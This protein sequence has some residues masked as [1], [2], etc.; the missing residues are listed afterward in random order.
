MSD[1]AVDTSQQSGTLSD[2]DALAEYYRSQPGY[3]RI[4]KEYLLP[5]ESPA[6]AAAAVTAP[7]DASERDPATNYVTAPD[8]APAGSS[9]EKKRKR[10]QNKNRKFNNPGES[11]IKLCGNTA[12][13]KPCPFGASCKFTHSIPTYLA[14]KPP[15]ISPTCPV[16]AS[17][18]R[19]DAG[20][21]CR[22]LSGH[23]EK[24]VEDD[25]STWKLVVDEERART[26]EG[27][28]LN[29]VGR[30]AQKALRTHEMKLPKS[31]VYMAELEKEI[32]E[33]KRADAARAKINQTPENAKTTDA[34]PSS[35]ESGPGPTPDDL[36]DQRATYL[37]SRYRPQEKHRLHLSGAKI[38]APL[39]TVGNIPFRRICKSFGAD[40]TVSEMGL[41][42][43]LLQGHQPEWALP[44][45][46]I[47]ER[48]A[49]GRYGVQIAGGKIRNNVQAA[50]ALSTLCDDIDFIDLNSGCPID[51]VYHQGAGSALLDSPLKLLR[52]ARGM[53]QVSAQIPIT[54]KIRTG[55][56]DGHPTALNLIKRLREET[57]GGVQAVTL[58]GRSRQQRYTRSADWGYIQSCAEMV[59]S[60][61]AGEAA[62]DIRGV[63][64]EEGEFPPMAFVGNGDIYTFEDWHNALGTG[65]DAA[66]IARG[67]L[68]KPWIF[69]EIERGQHIDKTPTQRLDILRDFANHGLEYWGADAHGIAT[70]RRFLCESM[71]FMH[72]YIPVSVLEEG[73]KPS[74]RERAPRW[75]A[76]DGVEEMLG[77]GRCGDWVKLSEMFLG[78]VGEGWEFVPK[79]K[80]NSV[81]G[82]EA[83]G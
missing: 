69:E 51:L 77:S 35:A 33:A 6:A 13:N 52:M 39:T 29:V 14:S 42:A 65:V 44:R 70:T 20:W 27:D 81:E 54:V 10:G 34:Q 50:E 73:W 26:H 37:E 83:Q 36:A 43:P 12:L 31:E 74:M 24:V 2:P 55:T 19:C 5:R 25:M 30:D 53:S 9:R 15:D 46:H 4:K 68:I 66:M 17:T 60:A 18:G 23:V 16:F 61:R 48:S 8:P 56:R 78:P 62:S 79:H 11:G 28:Y 3:A 21:K 40:V 7:E 1:D 38:L 41:S 59:A 72:R 47:S 76:R 58:H 67:A 63:Q 45:A 71:S 75:R 80:S 82:E 22:F 57:L 49:G 64:A 32:E